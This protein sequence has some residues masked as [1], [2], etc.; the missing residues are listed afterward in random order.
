MYCVQVNSKLGRCLHKMR[1]ITVQPV[2]VCEHRD[3]AKIL[4][5]SWLLDQNH[6]WYI[7]PEIKYTSRALDWYICKTCGLIFGNRG[8][9]EDFRTFKNVHGD[10]NIDDF[11][12]TIL[13]WR[14]TETPP[15]G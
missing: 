7:E 10:F 5:R 6:D 12:D 3:Y 11:K 2:I 8:M 9:L 1:L 4:A 15:K 13:Y 14:K